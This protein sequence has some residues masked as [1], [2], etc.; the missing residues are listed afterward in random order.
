[1]EFE[2]QVDLAEYEVVGA[3]DEEVAVH[4]LVDLLLHP[5]VTRNKL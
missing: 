1:M 5:T 2:V 4:L 3:H